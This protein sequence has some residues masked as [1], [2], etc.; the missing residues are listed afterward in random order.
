MNKSVG[1]IEKVY[2][3]DYNKWTRA[4]VIGLKVRYAVMRHEREPARGEGEGRRRA[5]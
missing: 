4:L 2:R 1:Y 3:I 5:D